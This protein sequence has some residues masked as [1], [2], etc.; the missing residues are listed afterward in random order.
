MMDKEICADLS[1]VY[2]IIKALFLRM[3][4]R[5]PGKVIAWK[6]IYIFDDFDHTKLGPKLS[7]KVSH[8]FTTSFLMNHDHNV[9]M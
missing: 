5:F 2:G 7:K 1:Y 8:N 4:I 6:V 3:V 9:Q